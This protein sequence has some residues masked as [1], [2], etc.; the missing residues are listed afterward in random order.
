MKYA[1]EANFDVVCTRAYFCCCRSNLRIVD[2]R[3]P[4]A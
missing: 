2:K 4:V 3:K 1:A